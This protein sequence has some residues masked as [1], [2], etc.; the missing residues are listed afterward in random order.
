MK[1]YFFILMIAV[2]SLTAF[3][4]SCNHKDE[5]CCFREELEEIL[6]D[7]SSVTE[8]NSVVVSDPVVD[9][10]CIEKVKQLEC[11]V[12]YYRKLCDSLSTTIRYED[13]SNARKIEKIKYYI[14]CVEKT[15]SNN[16][17]FFGW[18]KRTI[19]D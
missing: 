15:P 5:R 19:S 6:Q 13:Y 4:S 3:F 12:D 10:V 18:I 1:K 8:V 14:K 17:F 9:Y 11:T 2:L 16:E 7:T